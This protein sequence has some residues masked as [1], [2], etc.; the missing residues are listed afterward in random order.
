MRIV[1]IVIAFVVLAALSAALLYAGDTN[2]PA[3]PVAG[4]MKT[5]IQVEPRTAIESLPFTITQPGSYYLTGNLS[6][7]GDG[8]IVSASDVTIDLMG[9][10]ITGSD[11]NQFDGIGIPLAN[12][13][14]NLT[15]R[16]GTVRTFNNG[17]LTY[18]SSDGSGGR[19]ID[20]RVEDIG[21]IGIYCG[22]NNGLVLNCSATLSSASSDP[23]VSNGIIGA[24][25]T[26]RDCQAAGG[27]GVGIF[28]GAGAAGD[29]CVSQGNKTGIVCAASVVRGCVSTGSS[30]QN[31]QFISGVQA[32]NYAP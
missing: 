17:V 27:W 10:T 18:N 2:P 29:G 9:F 5:L 26:V 21:F 3:G 23:S 7:A 12:V 28:L 30:S 16:N 1:S 8:I 20:V 15:V 19:I 31:L 4:T 22:E 25:A 6:T 11:P 13:H 14:R 24:G 32:D